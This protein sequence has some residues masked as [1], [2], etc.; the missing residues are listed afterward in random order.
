MTAR[1]SRR[2]P[3][4]VLVFGEDANDTRVVEELL[5]GL[6]PE[7]AG[8]V[9]PFRKPPILMKDASPADMPDRV[10]R[11]SAIIDAEKATSE[12]IG[13]LAHEDCDAVEP[14]HIALSQKIEL[15]FQQRGYEVF[16]VVPAWETEAWFFLWP[17]ALHAYRPTWQKLSAQPHRNVGKIQNAK[18][19]LRRELRPKGATKTR[20]YRE[21]DAPGVAEQVRRLGLAGTPSGASGTYGQLMTHASTIAARVA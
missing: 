11:I 21:S 6:Y 5:C 19:A 1:R 9:T 10:A 18:E 14:A 20:D 13:I 8:L 15:N 16:P 7:L 3:S 4:K 17:A 12:V 2:R